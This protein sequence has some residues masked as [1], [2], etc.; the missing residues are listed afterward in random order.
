MSTYCD[1]A[2]GLKKASVVAYI[3]YFVRVFVYCLY[4]GQNYIS[5]INHM[6][7]NVKLETGE[8]AV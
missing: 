5:E 4:M 8:Q 6:M 7:M 1:C 3:F 2:L